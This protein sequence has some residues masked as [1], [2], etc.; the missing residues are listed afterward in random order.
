MLK[1]HTKIELTDVKT[2]KKQV[3]EKDNLVTNALAQRFTPYFGYYQSAM[4]NSENPTLP[5]WLSTFGGIFLFDS[6]IEEDVNTIYAPST[7]KMVGCGSTLDISSAG[8]IFKGTYNATESGYDASQKKMTIVYDYATSQANGTIS[9]VCL[10][11]STAGLGGYRNDKFYDNSYKL[12]GSVNSATIPKLTSYP[13]RYRAYAITFDSNIEYLFAVDV[14]NECAYYVIFEDDTS[15]TIR[16]KSTHIKKYSLFDNSPEILDEQFISGFTKPLIAHG[17]FN[18][19]YKD[20]ALYIVT[21]TNETVTQNQ[22]FVVT[23]IPFGSTGTF[24]QYEITNTTTETY[25]IAVENVY[26]HNGYIYLR[27]SNYKAVKINLSN[28]IDTVVL[29]TVGTFCYPQIGIE[30]RVYWATMYEQYTVDTDRLFISEETDNSLNRTAFRNLFVSKLQYNDRSCVIPIIG[31]KMYFVTE[32][33]DDTTSRNQKICFLRNYLA[34][35]NNISPVAK[36]NSQTMKIT[37][38]LQ[39]VSE[40]V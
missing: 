39:E 18:F 34:T 19:D 35:I 5:E 25:K 16:K 26:V 10:T 23:K 8:D 31:N 30:G 33:Y 21:A 32:D 40:N 24:N 9:C 4:T 37:Y 13:T 27:T 28:A 20:N 29:G 14:A 3:I 36:N 1:G 6:E 12:F 11:D 38:T 7:A 17:S 22:T 2:G 15:V